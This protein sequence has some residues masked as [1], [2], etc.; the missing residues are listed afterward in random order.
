MSAAAVMLSVSFNSALAQS[1][2][3]LQGIVADVSGA[4]K[5]MYPSWLLEAHSKPADAAAT[6]LKLHSVS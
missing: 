4:G 6:E 2:A 5:I 1:T 3:A